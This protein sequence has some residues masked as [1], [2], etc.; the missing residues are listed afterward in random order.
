MS[1]SSAHE[2]YLRAIWKLGEWQDHPVTP[3]ELSRAL[4]LSPS[5]VSE[6]LQRL[7]AKGLIR[8]AR[9]GKI[10]LTD[11]GRRQAA[12]MVRIHR[13]VETALVSYLGYSWD[14]VHDEA[15]MLEHAVSDTLVNRLDAK[16]GHPTRDPHGDYIPDVNGDIHI[17]EDLTPLSYV[18]AGA[19]ATVVT[20]SDENPAT[21]RELSDHG[22]FPGTTVSVAASEPGLGLMSITTPE[23][24]AIKLSVAVGQGILVRVSHA[25]ETE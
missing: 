24:A 8:H 16:M 25:E 2:D 14:E 3:S 13:L 1:L 21:L 19:K 23:G 9:Y 10:T 12:R 7:V 17:T 20:V 11:E 4:G 15:E 6:G 22:I 5:T 18:T